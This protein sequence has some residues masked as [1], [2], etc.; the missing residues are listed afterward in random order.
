VP[1]E[2]FIVSIETTIPTLRLMYQCA[3]KVHEKWPGGDPEE[4]EHLELLKNRLYSA[5]MDALLS[6]GKI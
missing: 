1:E 6:S 2:E 3:Q 5:L 4:Q